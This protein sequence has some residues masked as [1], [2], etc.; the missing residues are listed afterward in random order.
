MISMFQVGLLLAGGGT[1]AASGGSV[2]HE[3]Y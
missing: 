1:G 2:I 3:H